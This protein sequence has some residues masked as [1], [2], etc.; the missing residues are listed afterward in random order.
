[1]N[2]L[3]LTSIYPAPEDKNENVTKVVRYFVQSWVKDGHNVRVIHNVHR[4]PSI[5]HKLPNVIKKKL[6]GYLNFYIPD[7]NDVNTRHFS[8]GS[9]E[10]CRFPIVKYIPHG[11]PS[12]KEIEKQVERIKNVLEE[13]SFVPD[14]IMGHWCSPQ[15]KIISKLKAIYNCKTSLVLH[16]RGYFD[17]P[18]SQCGE[19]L[20]NIDRLGC[21]SRCEAQYVSSVLNMEKPPFVCYSGVPDSFVEGRE[22]E[23]EKFST[24]N[25]KLRFIFVGRLVE[26]KHIDKVLRALAKFPK[27]FV[28]DVIGTGSEEERLKKLAAE[29]G[30]SDK[31]VFHGR[32]PREEVLEHL[33]KAHAF[34][35]I[36][37]GEVFG[38]VYLEAMA[39]SCVTIGSENEGIDGVIV[40][41]EN[42][43]LSPAA[44]EEGLNKTLLKLANMSEDE[45]VSIAKAGFRTA[46]EFTDSNV[47][48][49]YLRDACGEGQE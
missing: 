7:I 33:R 41:G 37:K 32:M 3:M 25:E 6:A 17:S 23:G 38:L 16:G 28:F 31:V 20:P 1:M 12:D 40:D 13:A 49:W 34:L 8:D 18:R 26:M 11:E 47:A 19:Y 46:C 10:V 2:I 35:M 22:F 44:S 29:L 30:I 21:R 27:P 5:V 42:G 48:R 9:V 43:L 14:I 36:S 4:Y 39:A 45:L 15:L 24:V